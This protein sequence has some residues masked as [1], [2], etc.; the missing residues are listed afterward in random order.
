MSAGIPFWIRLLLLLYPRSYRASEGT[1]VAQSMA[2]CVDRERGLG[3]MLVA[4][5]LT[6][7]A[8]QASFLV[9]RDRRRRNAIYRFERQAGETLMQ[10]ILYDIRDGARV[11]RRAPL[12]SLV[13]AGTLALAIGANTAVFTVV[14]SV[15]LRS[16]PY[17]DPD[18]LVLL[19]QGMPWLNRPSG[20]SAPDFAAFRERTQSFESIAAFRSVEYELSGVDTPERIQA[21]RISAT[22]FDVLGVPLTAGRAFTQ[23][24]DTGR[25]PVAIISDALWTRKFGADHDVIGK[26]LLLDRRAFTIVG[27]TPP[28]FRFPERGPVLNNQ[29]ADVYVPISFTNDELRAFGSMYNNSVVARLRPGVTI[30]QAQGE[31][32]AVSRRIGTDV[33]PADLRDLGTA[34]TINVH[35]FR[36]QVVGNVRVILFVLLASV[37]VVLLVATADIAGLMLTRAAARQRELAVRAALG[38]GRFRLIRMMLVE[39]IVLATLGGV[40]GLGLAWWGTRALLAFSPIDLPRAQAISVDLRVLV[41]TFAV[42]LLAALICG[43][44]PAWESA[45]RDASPALKEGARTG[46]V[47]ARQRRVFGTLVTLQFAMAIV[48]LAAGGLLI[49]SFVRLLQINPGIQTEGA[50]SLATNLPAATYSQAGDIRAFYGRLFARVA[51]LPGVT[52]V[53]AGTSLPLAIRERR[54]FTIENPSPAAARF[55]DALAHDWIAG[56]YFEALGIRVIAGRALGDADTVSSEPTIVVNETMRR[57]WPGEDPV[58]HRIAWGLPRNHG[59]WM[60]IVGVVADVKLAGLSSP[61]EPQTWSPWVQ[62]PDAQLAGNI[63]G[64]FRGLR[65]IVRATVPPSSLIPAIRQEVRAL[66]PA[67]PITDVKTLDDVVSDSTGPQRFNAALLGAFAGI[68]LL[69]AAVGVA[70]VLAISVSR[71]TQEIGIRLA[72]GARSGDVLRMVLGQGLALVLLGLAIGLP[73]AFLAT[74]VLATLLFGIGAHDPLTF[75][76]ATAVLLLVALVACAIPAIRASRV[77]PIRAL[78]I[79]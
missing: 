49:R 25:R 54:A 60:R 41:F 79:D 29:P 64:I 39:T 61:T 17:R 78:R 22:L 36:D 16:L 38:A 58:G 50:I 13:A 59:P 10:S 55:S 33:Y 62:V 42:T 35:Q 51:S 45:R 6:I 68:A 40:A 46:S 48:L 44:V 65:L 19:Y 15:L 9:R 32:A 18:R 5:H 7:D 28:A 52:A 27:V 11:L 4:A 26:P 12:F 63:L 34:L 47:S 31:V 37:L 77:D 24:E 76:G 43:L 75:G 71:R 69:L 57:Y 53:G 14:N 21:A 3:R 67:L 30:A 56:R 8:V 2:E 20:F 73:C 72:L 70:G 66:D 74:R 1:E 23:E